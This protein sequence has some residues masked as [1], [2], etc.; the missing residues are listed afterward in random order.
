MDSLINALRLWGRIGFFFFCAVALIIGGISVF[1]GNI[2]LRSFL[3]V[4][5]TLALAFI[6]L[7]LAGLYEWLAE[8]LIMGRR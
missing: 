8:K 2:S 7:G 5:G 1:E 6:A 3:V 4:L